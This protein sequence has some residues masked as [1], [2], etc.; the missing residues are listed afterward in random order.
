MYEIGW[1]AH[2]LYEASRPGARL[3]LV[4]TISTDEGI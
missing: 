2:S 3:L 4:N 1:L